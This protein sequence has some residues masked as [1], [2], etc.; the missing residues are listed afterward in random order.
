MIFL[1]IAAVPSQFFPSLFAGAQRTLAKIGIQAESVFFY[2]TEQE[3]WKLRRE[4]LRV[5]TSSPGEDLRLLYE[6][7]VLCNPPKLQFFAPIEQVMLARMFHEL[8]SLRQVLYRGKNLR[9][10]HDHWRRYNSGF[11]ALGR[12]FCQKNLGLEQLTH[13]GED[14]YLGFEQTQIHYSSGQTK[15]ELKSLMRWNCLANAPQ[16]IFWEPRIPFDVMTS[17]RENQVWPK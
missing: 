17:F 6:T 5:K 10:T 12:L 9:K 13:L 3:T 11:R 7:D 2:S 1:V 15:T 14:I 4:C 16:R 8:T